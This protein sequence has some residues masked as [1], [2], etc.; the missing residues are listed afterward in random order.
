MNKLASNRNDDFE[1]ADKKYWSD[2]WDNIKLPNYPKVSKNV[3]KT[4]V[5]YRFDKLFKNYLSGKYPNGDFLEVGC[6][7]G[8]WLIYFAKEFNLRVTGIEYTE[9]G[10]IASRINL[11]LAGVNGK[12]I[13]DDFFSVEPNEKFDIVFSAGFVEHFLD[14]MEVVKRHTYFLKKDGT[15]IIVVPN[16]NGIFGLFQ[17]MLDKEIYY[18]HKL[19]TPEDFKKIA[20]SLNLNILCCKYFGSWNASIVN[21]H[22]NRYKNLIIPIVKISNAL[23]GGILRLIKIEP[24]HRLF[25]PYIVFIAKKLNK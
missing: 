10:A 3:F 13:C 14:T 4:Y 8:G 2:I 7:P 12:I 25:P 20:E 16:L 11:S 9:N 1:L 17:K 22:K 23:I 19:L 6:A 24:E 15:L 5:Y 21:F 18:K